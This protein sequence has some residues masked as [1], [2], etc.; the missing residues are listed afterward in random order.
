M[1]QSRQGAMDERTGRAVRTGLGRLKSYAESIG[2]QLTPEN[3]STLLA[4]MQA[5]EGQ[6][7]VTAEVLDFAARLTPAEVAH[8]QQLEAVGGTDQVL[9]A[10]LSSGRLSTLALQTIAATLAETNGLSGTIER[11][12]G[13]LAENAQQVRDNFVQASVARHTPQA[14]DSAAMQ[15][16]K[17]GSQ[18]QR[19]GADP[20]V[21]AA[22]LKVLERTGVPVRPDKSALEQLHE[23]W[24]AARDIA[25]QRVPFEKNF[26]TE[27]ALEVFAAATGDAPA[28]WKDFFDEIESMDTEHGLLVKLAERD[29]TAQRERQR[30]AWQPDKE[31]VARQ[32]K[33]ANRRAALEARYDEIDS[34]PEKRVREENKPVSDHAIVYDAQDRPVSSGLH[35]TLSRQYDE[36]ADNNAEAEAAE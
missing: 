2:W 28:A 29:H 27:R 25:G 14:N 6:R 33:E 17:R 19:L 16:L 31:T 23:W 8:L 30:I 18:L 15:Q 10:L 11:V 34:A 1:T 24:M 21:Q 26:T 32:T 22:A 20:S 36:I 9:Q 13:L 12:Q 35:E 3:A 5:E 7:Q 4:S